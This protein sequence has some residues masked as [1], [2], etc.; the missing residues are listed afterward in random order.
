MVKLFSHSTNF[1]KRW[2]STWLI[3]MIIIFE[4]LSQVVV[5]NTFESPT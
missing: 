3:Y 4:L 1:I 5:G 2:T